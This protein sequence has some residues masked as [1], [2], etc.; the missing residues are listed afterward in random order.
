VWRKALGDDSTHGATPIAITTHHTVQLRIADVQVL[1]DAKLHNA[2]AVR[3]RSPNRTLNAP[4]AFQSVARKALLLSCAEIAMAFH[5]S[6]I[7]ASATTLLGT[8]RVKGVTIARGLRTSL[9]RVV[10]FQ[11]K[12]ASGHMRTAWSLAIAAIRARSTLRVALESE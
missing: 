1:H 9:S 3:G 12:T 7:S 2:G 6:L 5:G 11:A 8:K 4:E 10:M